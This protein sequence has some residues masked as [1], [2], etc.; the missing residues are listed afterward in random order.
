MSNPSKQDNSVQNIT[1]QRQYAEIEVFRILKK[2]PSLKINPEKVR[3]ILDFLFQ[4]LPSIVESFNINIDIEKIETLAFKSKNDL[5]LAKIA[6][7]I[8]DYGNALFHL[9]QSVEKTV[10]AYGLLLG[11]IEDPQE[12]IGHRTPEVYLKMLRFSWTN[13]L[14]NLFTPN[15]NIPKIISNLDSLMQEYLFSWNKIPGKDEVKLIEFLKQYYNVAWIKKAKIEKFEDDKTIRISIENNYLLLSLNNENT[16]MNLIIDDGR[17]DEFIVK[18][19][20]GKLKISKK[21][22]SCIELDK[23]ILL[24]L[25]LYKTSSK[26][27]RKGLSKKEVKTIITEVK[28]RYGIDIKERYIMQLEFAFLLYL[29]SFVTWIYAIE[30]RYEGKYDQLNINDIL[31]KL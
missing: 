26:Q 23:N 3:K 27:V 4:N 7:D 12:E 13:D 2:S 8:K 20:N 24:F 21:D 31:I 19:K 14:S 22:N 16:K 30:P 18:K 15:I 25:D 5:K 1:N 9:Q 28:Q 11:V 17:T 6:Y 29:L 10:K